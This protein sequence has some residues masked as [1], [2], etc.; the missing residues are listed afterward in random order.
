MI[1]VVQISFLMLLFYFEVV[2]NRIVKL[3]Y[4]VAIM[5]EVSLPKQFHFYKSHSSCSSIQFHFCKRLRNIVILHSH[6]YKSQHS[7]LSKY[8][9][10]ALSEKQICSFPWSFDL[11]TNPSLQVGRRTVHRIYKDECVFSFFLILESFPLFLTVQTR[12]AASLPMI[13]ISFFLLL[14]TG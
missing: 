13:W 10:V 5:Q 4:T 6:F 14:T 3:H 11:T 2:Q 7:F 12:R 1:E 8:Y 9:V